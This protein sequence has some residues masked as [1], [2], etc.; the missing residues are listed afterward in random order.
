MFSTGMVARS[1][2]VVLKKAL[3]SSV[4]S[5]ILVLSE[6][7]GLDYL[8]DTSCKGLVLFFMVGCRIKK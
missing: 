1:V 2:G 6:A 8:Q 5:L 3:A 4:S 7:E